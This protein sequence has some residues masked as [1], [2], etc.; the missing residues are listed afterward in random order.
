MKTYEFSGEKYKNASRHQKEWGKTLI[1]KLQLNG[2]ETILDLGCGDGALTYMISQLVPNGNVIGID[3]SKNMIHSALQ[4]SADNLLFINQNINDMVYNSQFD[5]IFSNAALH[6]ITDHKRLLD[7]CFKALRPGGKILWNFAANGNCQTFFSVVKEK[8]SEEKYKKYFSSFEWPWF[9]PEISE[10]E[11]MLKQS[12]FKSYT[13][14]AQNR[15][16]SFKDIQEMTAWIDQPSIVPF[17]DYLPKQV[18]KQFRNEV[19]REMIERC[20]QPDGTCYET[21]RRI[22]VYAVKAR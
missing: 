5:I 13:I 7:N 11:I 19:V 14:E 18:K 20:L 16:R 22:N 17:L 6:W 8:I 2:N 3:S 10:Y 1:S 21:F 12:N 15:D 9:M 4:Y